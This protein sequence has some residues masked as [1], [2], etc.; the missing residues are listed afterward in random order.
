MSGKKNKAFTGF[1]GYLYGLFAVSALIMVI[2]CITATVS[3][4]LFNYS[5]W[6]WMNVLRFC[7][8]TAIFVILFSYFKIITNML[9][10][11]KSGK[12]NFQF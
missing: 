10:D 7:L 5:L 4:L 11:K 8:G 3:S 12:Y 6:S 2:F 9:F 1:L